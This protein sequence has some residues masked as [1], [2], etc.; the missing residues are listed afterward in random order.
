MAQY[1]MYLDTLQALSVTTDDYLYLWE[2]QSGKIWFFGNIAE[3]YNLMNDGKPYYEVEEWE[4]IVYSRDIPTLAKE[5]EE[6][7]GGERVIHN[8]NY[9]LK[10]KKGRLVWVNCRGTVQKDENGHAFAMIGRISDTVLLC[11]VDILTGMFNSVKMTADFKE[12]FSADS[13]G[14]LMF[15][16]VDNLKNI[17]IKRGRD[18]GNHIL[19]SVAKVLENVMDNSHRIYRL[20]GDSFA[21]CIPSATKEEV[22]MIYEKIQ[23]ETA[24]YCTI[25]AGAVSFLNCSERDTGRLYQ[26]AEEALDKAKK[27]GKNRLEFFSEEDYRRKIATIEL[28]EELGRSVENGFSGFSLAYQSQIKSGSYQLFGA[29]VLLRYDSPVCGRVMPDQFIPL[30][31]RTGLIC[32][33]GNWV[34]KTALAQCREWRKKMPDFHISVNM[35]YVQL[36]HPNIKTQVIETL[37]QSGVPGDALT[38]EVTESM[39]LQEFRYFNEI[40][41]EWRDE[42]IEVSVDDFG[43]GYSSLGYLKNLEIDEIKIDRCFVRGI[44]NSSYNYRL[45]SSILA[46]ASDTQIQVCCEGVEEKEELQVLEE[47]KPHRLQG[48]LFSKPCE[49]EKFEEMYFATKK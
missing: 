42:G 30:L 36:K 5:I 43:T 31:E 38:L 27:A 2:L 18:E 28:E 35:S 11:K 32:Q 20:D 40:F 8:M 9:R 33:V 17:N 1:K 34:L 6:I 44:Q 14:F 22:Q 46:L 3:E 37:R 21:L 29:E 25:S 41:S 7:I 16:G 10:N 49:K 45:L 24:A 48:Y 26:Y 4:K 47:L 23:K 13:D 12:M 39:Q 15:L 19:K